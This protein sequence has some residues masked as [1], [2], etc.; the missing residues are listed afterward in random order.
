MRIPVPWVYI[1][2]FL[3]GVGL[4]FFWSSHALASATVSVVGWALVTLGSAIAGWSLLIFWKA[5]TTTV[6]GKASAALVTWG[7][8][9]FTRNPMY[10]SLALVYLG[11]AGIL[12]QIWPL[13]LLPLVL[14]YVN[15]IVIPVEEAKL[16]EVF[17][18]DYDDYR[19]QVRR[20]L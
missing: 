15:W 6:P 2:A 5:R 9:R 11:E 20:W 7:P 19:M 17:G 12:Q 4:D 1:L 3:A 13:A 18:V 14:A 10:V 16:K 8:Y